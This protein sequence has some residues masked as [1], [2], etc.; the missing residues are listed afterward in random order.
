MQTTTA[1]EIAHILNVPFISLDELHWE[2]NW[3]QSSAESFKVKVS[4]ALQEAGS[5]W[6]VEGDY[7]VKLGNF[8]VDQ[9]TDIICMLPLRLFVHFFRILLKACYTG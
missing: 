7:K 2:P 5:S 6:V 1:R 9:T 4:N 3:V 8:V